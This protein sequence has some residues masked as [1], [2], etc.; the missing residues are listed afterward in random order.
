MMGCWCMC[1]C[2]HSM[3]Q[4]QAG[5]WERRRQFYVSGLS[6]GAAAVAKHAKLA[7]H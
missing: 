6:G 5:V 2:M 7:V 1:L 3:S 4:H